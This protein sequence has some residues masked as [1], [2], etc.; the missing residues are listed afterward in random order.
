MKRLAGQKGGFIRPFV[1]FYISVFLL[2]YVSLARAINP[3]ELPGRL[4][5]ALCISFPDNREGWIGG[6]FGKIWHTEDGGRT[7]R[8]QDSHTTENIADIYF[9]DTKNGWA[10]G[11]AGL[12]IHTSDGGKEW[13]H[14]KSPFKYFWKAVY[15]KDKRH[16][17]VAGEMGT[18]IATEDGGRTWKTLIT[19]DDV[20]FNSIT[21]SPDG[22]GWVS[23]EFGVIYASPD[24]RKW[25]LQDNG[26]ASDN[27]T[28]WCISYIG[29]HRVIASGVGSLLLFKGSYESKWKAVDAL[30]RFNGE[31]SLF[32]IIRFHNIIVAVGLKSIY[33]CKNPFGPWKRAKIEGKLPYGEWLYDIWNNGDR[34]YVLGVKGS[35]YYSDDGVEWRHLKEKE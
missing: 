6:H 29:N 2:N 9:V 28:V 5:P 11:H 23:G 21:F 26:V 7:W 17:W 8:L 14:Q 4:Y 27:Y 25:S 31:M 12:I 10:V 1:L 16:G 33:F 15:F 18:V 19:G 13:I 34:L 20:I 35:I 3:F 32:R 22:H 24:S 30:K